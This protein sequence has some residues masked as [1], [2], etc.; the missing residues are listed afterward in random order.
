MRKRGALA[1]PLMRTVGARAP[2]LV[3]SA[4]RKPGALAP[5]LMLTVGARAP[6]LF[7][8]LKPVASTHP[9]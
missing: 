8:Y 6:S 9:W 4:T 5:P 3:G 7:A 2:S 1:S